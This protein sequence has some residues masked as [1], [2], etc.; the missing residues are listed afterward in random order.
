MRIIVCVCM[1][2]CV[3]AFTRVRTSVCVCVC[4]HVCVCDGVRE[5]PCGYKRERV[6]VCVLACPSVM[7]ICVCVRDSL[8]VIICH[9]HVRPFQNIYGNKITCEENISN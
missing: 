4:L 1:Q 5:L 8:L 9:K 3:Y 6:C 7:R 2:A